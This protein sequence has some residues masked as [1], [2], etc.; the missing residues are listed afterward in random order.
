MSV[1][2]LLAASERVSTGAAVADAYVRA[3]RGTIDMVP[4]GAGDAKTGT[5]GTYRPVISTC[6]VT[7]PQMEGCYAL[8]GNVGIHQRRAT[9]SMDAAVNA[10]VVAIIAA[11]KAGLGAARLHVSG[12]F[13]R[14][15]AE[16]DCYVRKLVLAL[17]QLRKATGWG[18]VLAWTYTHHPR[19][20]YWA[21][22]LRALGVHVRESEKLGRNGAVVVSDFEPDTMRRVRAESP[23][24]VAKC[25]AQLR[26]TTC[27]E[28]RLCWERPDVAIAFAAH[29]VFK[30][31][32]KAT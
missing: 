6:P 12:D 4:V 14:S 30:R 1:S 19:A 20:M 26:D 3:M 10:A 5:T 16:V 28:C 29:G 13:G 27:V 22:L 7:C 9:E 8:G 23:A 31:K 21:P 18:G 25:P 15:D 11:R 2:A 24:P 32:V 17:I